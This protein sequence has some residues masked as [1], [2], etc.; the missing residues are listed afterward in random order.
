MES[1]VKL[2]QALKALNL[3]SMK[4]VI[5]T[6]S[7]QRLKNLLMEIFNDNLTLREDILKQ[8]LISSDRVNLIN[9]DRIFIDGGNIFLV[10]NFEQTMIRKNF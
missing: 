3:S 5:S 10:N 8:D 1:E 4:Y 2:Q 9:E 7:K 6:K